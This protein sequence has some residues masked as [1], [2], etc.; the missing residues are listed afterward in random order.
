MLACRAPRIWSSCT[1][2]A[3]CCTGTVPPSEIVAADGVP[4]FTSTK[5][6]P[7]R[8]IRGLIVAVASVWM[9]RPWDSMRMVTRAAA[10]PPSLSILPTPVTLPTLTPPM[11][12][13]EPLL[14][15]LDVRKTACSV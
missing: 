13:G 9:G 1:G 14:M 11:R 3:V 10:A 12:T 5:K 7:S 4:G 15:L 8:K 2:V 6:L